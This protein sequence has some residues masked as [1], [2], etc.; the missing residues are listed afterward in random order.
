[1]RFA[2]Q[3]HVVSF[4]PVAAGVQPKALCRA[5]DTFDGRVDY[6]GFAGQRVD[7]LPHAT[8]QCAK[9]RQT[10]HVHR[11]AL[12]QHA[13][14]QAAVLAFQLDQ[15]RQRAGGAQLRRIS[16]ID[17]A[18]QRLGQIV[19]HFPAIMPGD[20]IRHRAVFPAAMPSMKILQAHAQLGPPV[21]Q[22]CR[23]YGSQ[24]RGNQELHAIGQR[25]EPSA[26]PDECVAQVIVRSDDFRGKPQ[27]TDQIHSP[28]L[29][30]KKAVGAAL[31]HEAFHALGP[32][33]AAQSRLRFE[34]VR[35][36]AGFGEIMRGGEAGNAAAHNGYGWHWPN[37]TPRV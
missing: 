37:A 18:Q 35:A 33:D 24:F 6:S 4:E 15:I 29:G 7:Q 36:D 3:H 25:D 17:S 8:A 12:G 30:G 27:L 26:F 31:H 32:D 16:A 19:H 10:L 5:F 11:L 1:M 23:R 14:R 28:R 20:E 2:C 9:D 21:Q 13:A 34:Q 22:R